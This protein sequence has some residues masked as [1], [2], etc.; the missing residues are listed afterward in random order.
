MIND[1]FNGVASA[2]DKVVPYFQWFIDHGDA[3]IGVIGAIASAFV[4]LKVA[5]AIGSVFSAFDKAE[6]TLRNT[7]KE[8]TFLN[9]A[10]E[11]IG[12]GPIPIII[13]AVAAL[14]GA[15]VVAYNTS[16]TFRN[17]VN[18]LF[19]KIA[20]SVG[21]VIEQAIGA[22][23]GLSE[24]ISNTLGIA[25]VNLAPVLARFADFFSQMVVAIAP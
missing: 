24:V 14:V 22:F 6:E 10:F 1:F 19:S 7:K 5:G 21:P 17:A 16:E 9:K 25:L 8:I 11:V 4:V 2:I 23:S 12:M 3:V 20:E 18:N 15:L 13:A